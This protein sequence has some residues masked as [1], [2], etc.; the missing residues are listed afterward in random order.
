MWGRAETRHFREKTEPS[1]QPWGRVG[2]ILGGARIN[3]ADSSKDGQLCADPGGR[4]VL[5]LFLGSDIA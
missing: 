5:A 4:L 1:A 2:N 3:G